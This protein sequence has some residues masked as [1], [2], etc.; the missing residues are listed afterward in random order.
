VVIDAHTHL[1]TYTKAWDAQ[2]LVE[3][4]RDAGIDYCVLLANDHSNRRLPGAN[5]DQIS[6]AASRYPQL[7][8][9]GNIDIEQPQTLEQATT[10]IQNG[11]MFGLKL[12]PG[13]QNFYPSDERLFELYDL[14]Q[15]RKAPVVFHMG[16]LWEGATGLLKQAHPLTIDEVANKFPDLKIIIAHM[17]NPWLIDTG[18]VMLK[19]QNVYTDLSGFFEE[20]LPISAAAVQA[21]HRALQELRSFIGTF[22]RCLFGTDWPLY[23]QKEYLQ[24]FTSFEI[25]EKEQQRVLWKNATELFNIKL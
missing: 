14:C 16:L 23:N 18:A 4:M 1:G 3:S 8:P 19:N 7:I 12:F 21:Y 11:K 5:I 17:G 15:K 25:P 9:V 24:A 22:D 20:Y 10:Y 6:E 13:Y 2:E